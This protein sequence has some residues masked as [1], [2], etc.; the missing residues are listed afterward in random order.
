MS[1]CTVCTV[2]YAVCVPVCSLFIQTVTDEVTQSE[3]IRQVLKIENMIEGGCVQLLDKEQI[4]IRQGKF[5]N[6][7]FDCSKCYY[8]LG[9]YFAVHVISLHGLC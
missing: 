1:V 9:L 6:L 3:N 2:G 7:H 5:I 4:L 8:S